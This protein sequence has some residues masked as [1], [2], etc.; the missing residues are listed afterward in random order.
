MNLSV[1][2][3]CSSESI[4]CD[5]YVL[6][7]SLLFRGAKESYFSR[8][9]KV[10]IYAKYFLTTFGLKYLIVLVMSQMEWMLS[11][12]FYHSLLNLEGRKSNV[13]MHNHADIESLDEEDCAP[14]STDVEK[15]V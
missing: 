10:I 4:S 12:F 11:G 14:A 9:A 5:F 6:I 8:E 7:T 13:M 1:S 2:L 15:D 3:F